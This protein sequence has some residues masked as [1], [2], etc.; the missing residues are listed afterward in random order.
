MVPRRTLQLEEILRGFLHLI[1]KFMEVA[2]LGV[3]VIDVIAF[4]VKN[5][6]VVE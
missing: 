3:N 5:Y 2:S 4:I 1:Y 6:G